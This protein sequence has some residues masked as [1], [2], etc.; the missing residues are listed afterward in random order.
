MEQRRHSAQQ[1]A[2]KLISDAW[3][4]N[5]RAAQ[6]IAD[7]KQQKVDKLAELQEA[8]SNLKDIEK[9]MAALPE[10]YG[11]APDSQ[12]QKDLE[13]LEKYQNYKNGSDFAD[14]SKEEIERLNELQN[15][16]RTEYQNQ[17]LRLNGQAGDIRKKVATAERE[18]AAFAGTITDV[19]TD[20]LKSP[21]MLKAGN[22]ADKI[23]DAA[24]KEIFGLLINEG[25][26][27]IDD[28]MEEEQ[29]KA[30]KAEEEHKEQQERI[31]DVKEQKE[32]Q[33]KRIDDAKEKR[34]DQKELIE[35]DSEIDQL[36]LEA[37]LKHQNTRN[38][39]EA[40]KN[41]QRIIKENKLVN[42]DL[43]GIEID[44]DF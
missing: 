4:Q 7:M 39:N 40:Q 38:I 36:E 13:L 42:E 43:K 33:Q 26:D 2:M 10:K 22:A 19:K 27:N 29:E 18:L 14:F 23:M 16:P 44:F 32:E 11:I 30:E 15:M 9:D 24:D 34:D 17:V 1:Q 20:L 5:E 12:E 28:K 35:G 6:S 31:D 37:S 41:I 3:D 21:R 25:K 8:K